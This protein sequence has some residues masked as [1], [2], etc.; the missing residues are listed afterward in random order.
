M[1]P[2]K[3]IISFQLEAIDM[4]QERGSGSTVVYV[5]MVQITRSCSLS[6]LSALFFLIQNEL[7]SSYEELLLGPPDFVS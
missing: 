7:L 5:M 2:T 4:S 1:L 6:V 3:H